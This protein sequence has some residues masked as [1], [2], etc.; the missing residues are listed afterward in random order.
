MYNLLIA[1]GATLVVFVAFFFAVGLPWYLAL[2]I[3]FTVFTACYIL[4]TRSVMKK[5]NMIM[6]AAGKDLQG[7][8]I[9]K[10]IRSLQEALRLGPWQFSVKGQLHA[11]IGMIYYMKRDFSQ[12]F[13]HLQKTFAKNWMA[14][15]MLAICYMKRSKKDQMIAT[16]E[17]AA[18]W[19]PKE[20]LLWNLYAYCLQDHGDGAAAVKVLE[21][22]L[23]KLPGDER[24]A[25]NLEL[26]RDGKKMKMRS[27]GDL[28]LQFHLEKQSVVMKQQAAA[29]GGSARRKIVRK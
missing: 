2:M 18:Q 22:G 6:E 27:F 12:A 11:Q 13:P 26:V 3:A 20:S 14:M 10:A 29:L 8:R 15:G 25:G 28:W 7:Q 21:R 4:L 24:M 19:S 17:K 9:D 1:L 16:F 23:K 5:L